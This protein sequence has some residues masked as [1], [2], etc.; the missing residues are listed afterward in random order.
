MSHNMNINIANLQ[1]LAEIDVSGNFL[2]VIPEAMF[3]VPNILI[4]NISNNKIA[5]FKVPSSTWKSLTQ[6]DLSKNM[7]SALPLSMFDVVSIKLL[8]VNN[9]SISE[10]QQQFGFLLNLTNLNISSNLLENIEGLKPLFNLKYLYAFPQNKRT[11][12]SQHFG[13]F[14]DIQELQLNDKPLIFRQLKSHRVVLKTH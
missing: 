2:N 14:S 6:L 4:L 9:N 5:S 13:A 10:V 7:F 8:L 1:L 12:L 11:S 3:L